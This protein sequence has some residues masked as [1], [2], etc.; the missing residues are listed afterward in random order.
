MLKDMT[1]AEICEKLIAV[2]EGANVLSPSLQPGLLE[3]ISVHGARELGPLSVREREVLTL[4]AEGKTNRQIAEA[5]SVSA[6]TVK[7][8]LARSCRKLGVSDR[9]AAT[10]AAI[11]QGLIESPAQGEATTQARARTPT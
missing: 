6:A 1:G 4:V 8:H 3:Q 7:T 5:L 9:T 11:R 10:T 2:A